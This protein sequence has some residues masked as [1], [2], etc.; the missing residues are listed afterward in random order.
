MAEVY[1]AVAIVA[2]V[3]ATTAL[4]ASEQFTRLWPSVVVVVGYGLAFYMLSLCLKTIPVGVAYAI[5]TGLGM[6]LITIAGWLIYKQTI[7]LPV[8]L[9][10]MMII[11]GVVVIQ[12]SASK[13]PVA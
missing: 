1:L 8:I 3:I 6:V 4:K 5:W 2:E 11:G 7:D 9:G 10:M 12:L 13:P